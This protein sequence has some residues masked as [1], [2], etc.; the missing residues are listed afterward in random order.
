VKKET[1]ET[2]SL[3]NKGLLTLQQQRMAEQDKRVESIGASVTR[4]KEVAI[5]IGDELKE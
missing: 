4:T 5:A 2:E 1:P 3:D